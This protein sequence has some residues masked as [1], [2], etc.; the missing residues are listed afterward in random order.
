MYISNLCIRAVLKCP[1]R[2]HLTLSDRPRS[3]HGLLMNL[4]SKNRGE[5]REIGFLSKYTIFARPL[6]CDVYCDFHKIAIFPGPQP[7]SCLK[8]TPKACADF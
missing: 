5:A 8:D 6:V 4:P 1:E 7:D 2:V 3:Q